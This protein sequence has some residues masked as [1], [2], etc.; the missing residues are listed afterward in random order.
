MFVNGILTNCEAWHS[1]TK[2][3]IEDLE[4]MD[5]M[6]LRYILVAHAKVQ[7]EFLYLETGAIPLKHVITSRRL[8][9]LKTILNRPQT[10]II[11]QVYE[12]QKENP[13]KGDWVKHVEEDFD[14]IGVDINEN[15]IETM[16]KSK[17]KTI[18][19]NKI[20]DYTFKILREQ[21]E[22]HTKI[23]HIQ[24]NELCMQNYLKTH[25]LNN[26]EASLL[27]SLR[28][29]TTREF[30]SNFPY[31][32]DQMCVM[33]CI[34]LDTPQH[35]MNFPQLHHE[36]AHEKYIIYEDLFSDIISKQAAVTKLF[37]T[38]LERR[39][40]ASSSYIGP[41]RSLLQGDDSS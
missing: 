8:M 27:F 12:A 40:D 37:S 23:K 1:I 33:G 41:S 18:V 13:V 38:L 5:R 24:Y 11:R 35:C 17:Y 20:R 4:V 10:E 31:N 9:Y 14:M 19:K 16:T 39:E 29:Q 22:G 28:S 36:E 6:L 21:Q 7:T 3:H 30:R 15:E 2:Q 25:I 26:Q 34:E 32:S